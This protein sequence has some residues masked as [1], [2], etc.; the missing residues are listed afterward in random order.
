MV[1]DGNHVPCR[2]VYRGATFSINGEA[3]SGD[4]FTLLLAGYDVVMGTQWLT[5]LG[6]ILWDFGALTMSFWRDD[7]QVCW[8]DQAGPPSPTLWACTG[9]DLLPALLDAFA[10]V[11]TEPKG[12][13][14]PHTCNHGITL[15]LGSAP[16][17][18]RPY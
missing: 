4:F 8:C 10:A 11:F 18:V 5:S 15:L 7:H 17:A 2:G 6:P 13:S 16:V 1:A 9:D 3:F 12:M 14:L